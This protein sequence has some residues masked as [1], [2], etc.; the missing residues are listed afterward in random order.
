[1]IFGCSAAYIGV[2]FIVASVAF[3]IIIYKLINNDKDDTP[4]PK[5]HV[6]G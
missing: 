2:G 1:M 5:F 6:N 3:G 4:K